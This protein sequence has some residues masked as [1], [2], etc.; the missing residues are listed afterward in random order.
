M[1]RQDVGPS[2]AFDGYLDRLCEAMGHAK[3]TVPFRDYCTGLLMPLERKS[4]EPLAAATDPCR[5]SAHHQSL[6]HLVG[7]APWSDERLLLK[8]REEVLPAMIERG[9]PIKALII[10]DTSFPK[11]GRH[12][13]GVA[14]QYCGQLG[15][16]ENCQV[17]VSLS[18]ANA[19]ASLPVAFRL[20]LPKSWASDPARRSEAKVPE[21]I[22][23]KTKPQIALDQIR[24]A[25][26]AGTPTGVVLADAGYGI[27]GAFRQGLRDLALP[28]AVG[29]TS[30]LTVW[31]P[32]ES[33]LPPEP[34]C[35]RGR[36]P[37]RMRR[38]GDHQPL[39][40]KDL[41]EEL[42]P[43]AFKAVTWREGTN[44]PL[45]SRFAAVRVR[46]A[47]Q[48]FRSAEPREEEWLLIEW[49]DGEAEPSKYWLSTLPAQTPLAQLVETTKLRWRIER[50][51]LDLKQ[52]L[53][54]GHYEGRGWRGFH[55]HIS[56]CVAAYGFLV[57]EQGAIPPSA[58]RSSK[59]RPE[60]TLPRGS[61][62][63]RAPRQTR[64]P[65]RHI[66]GDGE[67]TS[68]HRYGK[69]SNAMSMLRQ[70]EPTTNTSFVTQ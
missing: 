60:P 39:S 1:D 29:I 64:A 67:T 19:V 42:R 5:V 54:L 25:I 33:P 63:A 18:L 12:S 34:Y 31:R 35:G 53:G 26:A 4:V 7:E 15:K 51:Y 49:P 68:H 62:S 2:V 24:A 41:A 44:A 32:G 55:H 38:D 69:T 9:G 17:A 43:E 61:R 37:K 65:R 50:D 6:L 11:K 46:H 47:G 21:T 56:L 10:D 70:N 48:D 23:F 36:P 14:R 66:L 58:N 27:D 22:T 57:L 40:V 8:V 16:R 20:Y 59:N 30:T 52:E 3:R 13:V 45:T 28:Y